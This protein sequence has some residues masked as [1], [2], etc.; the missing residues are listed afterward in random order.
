MISSQFLAGLIQGAVDAGV[1][2]QY[3]AYL[4]L[5]PL[6]ASVVATARHL[7]G[8]TTHGTFL[9]SLLALVWAE[10]GLGLGA[11]FFFFLFSWSWFSRYL[12]KKTLIRRFKINYLPRMAILLL[13]IALGLFFLALL[14]GFSFF[15]DFQKGIW[16][17]LVLVL[18]LHN[19]LET[20]INLSKK[21]A[22]A[23]LLETMIFSLTGYFLLTYRGLH[24]LVLAYP[25]LT[26]IFILI[27]NIGV[28]RFVGF[29]LLER[30]R[31]KPIV[32]QKPKNNIN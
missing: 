4:L 13:L 11:G 3:F 22:R 18:T 2:S 30:Y 31:F 25:A 19:F 9:A 15:L 26:I 16:P 1:P 17:F 23:S 20:Q 28:G 27:L 29:R 6:L 8:L 32:S 10:F 7:L 5:L 12:V 14:P 24:D 21:E